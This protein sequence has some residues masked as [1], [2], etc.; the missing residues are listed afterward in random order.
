MCSYPYRISGCSVSLNIDLHC[1]STVS[2]GVLA[3][4]D[5]VAR[6]H[7]NGVNVLA[8][9]DHDEIAG[10]A[11]AHSR[12]QELGLRF[13]NGVEIS[14]TWAGET[15]HIVGLNIDPAN[16]VLVEGLANTRNG[17]MR[18]AQQIAQSLEM[19][20][21]AGTLDEALAFA[22][23]PDLISRTH[24]AR[25]LVARGV[26][27][28]VRSVF[29]SYLSPGMPGYIPMQWATL[30]DAVT[31]IRVA[32]GVAIIAHPGR[33]RYSANAF[34]ELY[35]QFKDLGGT[36]IEVVSG[37]HT[38]DQY[39]EYTGVARRYGL[40]ASRGSDFHAP[41]EGRSDLGSL[42]PLPQGV[43]PVWHDWF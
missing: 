22:D 26:A 34:H 2:D 25:V 14:V 37:S 27:P 29:K 7:A 33:Y 15:V 30:A 43:R 12:A 9:T 38:P 35:A 17:R 41:G 39:H 4:V 31:W 21:H 24:F 40:L 19:A 28:D 18:R 20:G 13:I 36:G 8:L 11:E 42:P 23:N 16:P 1:H 5:V 6:A 10:L 32:G 3:P